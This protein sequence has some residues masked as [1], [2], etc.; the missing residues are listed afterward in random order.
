MLLRL[1]KGRQGAIPLALVVIVTGLCPSCEQKP[2]TGY[3][4][5][6]SEESI[7]LTVP[8]GAVNGSQVGVKHTEWSESLFWEFDTKLERHKYEE[9]VTNKAG[10]SS[11]AGRHLVMN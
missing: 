5:A 3:L 6:H 10:E 4:A 2:F 9:W 7:N 8:A 1:A 11:T